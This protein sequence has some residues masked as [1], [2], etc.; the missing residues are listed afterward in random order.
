VAVAFDVVEH[1]D[2]ARPRWQRR[3]GLLEIEAE[4]RPWAPP[5]LLEHRD[6]LRRYDPRQASAPGPPLRESDV[7]RQ[8]IEPG[9]ESAVT[10]ELPKLLPSPDEDILRQLLRHRRLSSQAEAEGIHPRG[11]VTIEGLEG[12]KAAGLSL[13]YLLFLSIPSVLVR[14]ALDKASQG[15]KSFAIGEE[16]HVPP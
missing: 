10:P 2:G 14:R 13:A 5:C 9:G 15:R 3:Q 12:R 8:R 11:I 6:I 4:L 1:E 16:F 7:D